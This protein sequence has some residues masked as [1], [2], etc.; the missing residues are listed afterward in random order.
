MREDELL[1][2]AD[3]SGFASEREVGVDASFRCDKSRLG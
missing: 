1:E 2:L 3:Q